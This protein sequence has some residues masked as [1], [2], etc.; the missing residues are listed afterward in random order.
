MQEMKM[1]SLLSHI[2]KNPFQTLK[3]Q[4]SLL[5]KSIHNAFENILKWSNPLCKIADYGFKARKQSIRM[6]KLTRMH[7]K[8]PKTV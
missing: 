4:P 6:V 3:K 7:T 8:M 1:S 5:L 2:A